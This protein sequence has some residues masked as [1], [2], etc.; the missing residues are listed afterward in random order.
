MLAVLLRLRSLTALQRAVDIGGAVLFGVVTLPFVLVLRNQSDTSVAAAIAVTVLLSMALALRRLAPGLAL[1]VAW[2]GAVVQMTTGQIP[3]FVDLA[4]LCVLYATSAYGSRRVMW[5]GLGSAIAGAVVVTGYLVIGPFDVQGS[6]P[7]TPASIVTVVAVATLFALLL[8]W[9]V[10]ALVRTA[11]RAQADRAAQELAQAQAAAEQHRARIA[12]DMH[13]IVAHSLA[14]IVA[15]ADGGRYAGA[16][17]PRAANAALTTIAS[18]ARVALTDVRL[19]LTQLR[20]RESEGPQPTLADLD[21]LVAQVRDA[22]ADLTV[23]I[24]PAPASAPPAAVQLAV[25]RIVQEALTNAMRHGAGGP[26]DVLI[27][28]H[29]DRVDLEVSNAVRAGALPAA[30]GHGIIG[31]RERAHLVGGTLTTGPRDGQFVV[32]ASLVVA[33]LTDPDEEPG[34]HA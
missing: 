26:V 24:D 14:V 32:S 9:T 5:W 21:V 23:D 33:E 15:Q 25:Y 1:A 27:S 28:W 30:D 20:H 3:S 12:R 18:T 6:D 10:G 13:D 31:M 7:W 16:S 2:G 4:I 34:G 22:G 29:P 8:A 19:L 11:R 17:D